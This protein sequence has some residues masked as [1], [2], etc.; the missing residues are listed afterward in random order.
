MTTRKKSRGKKTFDDDSDNDRE[1]STNK[2]SIQFKDFDVENFNADNEEW[3]YWYYRFGYALRACPVRVDDHKRD[4]LL[5][6]IS[7]RAFRVLID[8]FYA[9]ELEAVTFDDFVAVLEKNYGRKDMS[10]CER[11]K[12]TQ[13]TRAESETVVE[14]IAR[15]RANLA[16]HCVNESEINSFSELITRAGSKRYY[17]NTHPSRV[18]LRT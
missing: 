16:I 18:D 3:E 12:F 15:L 1:D 17:A 10:L 14:Y 6:K 4:Y 7:A 11:L 13:V 5:A 9:K 8:H 2:K